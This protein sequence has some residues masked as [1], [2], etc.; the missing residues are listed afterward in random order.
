MSTQKILMCLAIACTSSVIAQTRSYPPAASTDLPKFEVASVRLVQDWEKLPDAQRMYYM[1]PPGAGQ[2]TARNITLTNLI[3]FAFDLTN[4]DQ[5]TSR[6]AWLDS[7]FYDI[8]AK[9]DGDGGLSY[10]QLRPLV[11]QLLQERFHLTY[12]RETKNFK[13]YA[14]VIAKGGPKLSPTKGGATDAYLMGGKFGA[15]N[16]PVSVVAYMLSV[17]LGQHVVDKTELKEKYDMTL[18]F[19]PIEATDSSLPSIY[20]ALNEQL[21]LKLETA[22]VPVEMFVIDHVDREPTAN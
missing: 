19:A 4:T 18:N 10:E 8:A 9:P 7:T 3:Y 15:T 11:Q 5:I 21:G 13:G 6:P 20:T 16:S 1:S 2:F 12:H 14:L 17:L 22:T